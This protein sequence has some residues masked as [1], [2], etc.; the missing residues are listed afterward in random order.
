MKCPFCGEALV[1]VRGD[2]PG[3]RV[4]CGTCHALIDPELAGLAEPSVVGDD[5]GKAASTTAKS[6]AIDAFIPL[7]EP[8]E[9]LGES[10]DEPL[11]E[12]EHLPFVA[13]ASET[14]ESPEAMPDDS[15]IPIDDF[16]VEP[17]PAVDTGDYVRVEPVRPAPPVGGAASS[18]SFKAG[19]LEHAAETVFTERARSSASA[20]ESA[21]SPGSTAPGGLDDSWLTGDDGRKPSRDATDDTGKGRAP[22]SFAGRDGRDSPFSN[23]DL[24]AD[25]VNKEPP[26]V[27]DGRR[28]HPV[29]SELTPPPRRSDSGLFD[30]GVDVSF[31]GLDAENHESLFNEPSGLEGQ[32]RERGPD[33]DSMLR[34][35]GPTDASD[36]VFSGFSQRPRSDATPTKDD[37]IDIPL[38]PGWDDLEGGLDALPE[39]D[40]LGPEAGAA[41]GEDL[42][43]GS[44]RLEI[45]VPS[46]VLA[47]PPQGDAKQ[48]GLKAPRPR[49][50]RKV[51]GGGTSGLRLALLMVVLV[52]LV[53][54]ILGQTRYGYFGAKLF[55]GKSGGGSSGVA[56]RRG[57]GL[58]GR[59]ESGVARDTREAYEAEV[60]QLDRAL[61]ENPDDTAT[62]AALYELLL[63]Y[64]E[65]FPLAVSSDPLTSNRLQE[66][67][68]RVRLSGR[69][70][71]L[72]N[73]L[74]LMFDRKYD[75]ARAV[76]DS[77]ATA[78]SQ[79][80]E[81]LYFYGR[82]SFLQKAWTDAQKYFG[83]A[84]AANPK[85]NGARHF[86]A[87][88]LIETRDWVR[89]RSVVDQ[90]LA[91]VPDHLGAAVSL[92]EI[93]LANKKLDE[94]A[95]SA[96]SVINRAK[97]GADAQEQFQ[98]FSVL[99]RIEESRGNLEGRMT[100]L[101]AALGAQPT[102]QDTAATLG[103]MLLNSG[104]RGEAI[105]A[106]RPCRE[107]GC[108][109]EEFLL[110]Y[111]E[112]AF[113]DQQEGL[114][115]ATLDEGAK[116]YPE[117]PRF[118]NLLGEYELKQGRIESATQAF[119]KAIDIDPTFVPA[120]RNAAQTRIR[121]GRLSEANEI[122]A[123]GAIKVPKSIDLLLSLADVQSEQRDFAGAERTLRA[124][125][126]LDGRNVKAQLDLGIVLERQQRFES[127]ID[128][129]G[130]LAQRGVLNREGALCLGRAYMA[131]GRFKAARDLLVDL[132]GQ[133]KDDP[134]VASEYGRALAKAG[135]ALAAE[136]VLN[137]VIEDHPQHAQAHFYLATLMANQNRPRAAVDAFQAAV[138][139]NP[140]DPSIRLALAK[141]LLTI[142]TTDTRREARQQLDTVIGAYNRDDA[143]MDQRD[144]DAWAMR[145]TLLF[146]E[147]KYPQALK[148]FETAL[149]VSPGRTDLVLNVGRTLFEMARFD[150]AKPFFQRVLAKELRN[151]ESHY[152]LGRIAVRRGENRD[153]LKHLEAS[154][155]QDPVP[156]PDA[157][158]ILGMIYRDERMSGPAR[159]AFERYL[160]F[161][162]DGA[163]AEEVR[164][165]LA[166]MRP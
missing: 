151:Q 84:I 107:R 104:K 5:D 30:D 78:N 27:F 74:N 69:A 11:D 28:E 96:A 146:E 89:A 66:L 158:R 62:Q 6:E 122:L 127:V 26:P 47:P 88:S 63:R 72:A 138:L 162:P 155:M 132:H 12:Q 149:A 111:A 141:A 129:L 118:S 61:R 164:Q 64:R 113:D 48:A 128:V 147:E 82:L 1:D 161:V 49:K 143:L 101:R 105:G 115:E 121:A 22:D 3:G 70:A 108:N 21:A 54:V 75:E 77:I 144:A 68:T 116:L 91:D 19:Q 139:L 37:D 97:A 133:D 102:D 45:D 41:F 57:G 53:G 140:N 159:K 60:R 44:N 81:I 9:P 34:P 32:G 145:G 126:R 154:V 124:A 135:E 51:K 76:L 134:E 50:V 166:R 142:G 90:I 15:A 46:T 157:L 23:R 117:S 125:I 163:E 13:D 150:D 100:Q 160:R 14:T 56:T 123:A 29:F 38:P 131:L 40:S 93:Q 148:D 71:D 153:A 94:A 103:R 17:P 99:A 109:S 16:R 119:R 52:G 114:A 98:A 8:D 39:M 95:A 43:A 112:A 165:L 25:E 80:P 59:A 10:F 42:F 120:Y 36:D 65:R 4:E 136:A 130:T 156:N 110:T 106:M 137:K 7:I 58:A 86:L 73:M 92:A 79:D 18:Y 55:S 35:K 24:L 152:Y 33:F 85:A 31:D 67:R 2:V 83:M 87:R 20:G